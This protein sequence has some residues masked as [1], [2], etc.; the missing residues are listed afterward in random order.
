MLL[1]SVA[2]AIEVAVLTDEQ[3]NPWPGG[4]EFYAA[5]SEA[6]RQ[7]KSLPKATRLQLEEWVGPRPLATFATSYLVSKFINEPRDDAKPG[8]PLTSVSEF[9]EPRAAAQRLLD[10]FMALPNHYVVTIP[11]PATERASL[12][13]PIEYGQMAVAGSWHERNADFPPVLESVVPASARSIFQLSQLASEPPAKKDELALQ[14]RVDGYV[15]LIAEE[16]VRRAKAEFKSFVG[17]A[18]MTDLMTVS[19]GLIDTNMASRGETRVHQQTV[20]GWEPRGITDNPPLKDFM[21]GV[22][23]KRDA[24]VSFDATRL[25]QLFAAPDVG[26]NLKLAG[27]WIYDA[28]ATTNE[29]VMR[30]MQF[31]IAMEVLLQSDPGDEGL[32]KALANRCAYL[33]AD[34]ASER[35]KIRNDFPDL[36]KLRSQIVHNGIDRFSDDEHRKAARFEHYCKRVVKGE[37]RLA[38]FDA[39]P[40]LRDRMALVKAL[41]ARRSVS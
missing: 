36:Y 32:T 25:L 30:Y 9:S 5:L 10:A 39:D 16:P 37:L 19:K 41:R 26:K 12:P 2:K 14:I 33:I 17:L 24:E 13:G 27:R 6:E 11:L 34:S 1:E 3:K 38:L 40:G 28:I 35:E 15:G 7:L 29:P 23:F 22:K 31:A 20:T 4:D 18:L 8:A 21:P